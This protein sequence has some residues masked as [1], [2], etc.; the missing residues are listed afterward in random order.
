MRLDN[1]L[2]ENDY[3][4]TR[5]KA[6]IAIKNNN[7]LVNN[8]CINKNSYI[9]NS[10][11]EVKIVGEVLKYVSKGGLKLEKAINEFNIDLS[12][13]IMCDIGSSTG[14]FSD[15][16][17]QNNI[18]KIYAIDVGSN[19]MDNKIRNNKKIVLYEN[20]DF[21]K[22]DSNIL[23]DVDII[24]IDVS[25]ISVTKLLPYINKL[26]NVEEIVCLIKPQF[27]CGMEIASKYKGIIL[28]KDIHKNIIERVI[29]EF[30]NINYY[31]NGLTYS[32]IRGG[33]GN[34]EYLLYLT[35]ID[36]NY[37]YDI[38]NIIRDGFKNKKEI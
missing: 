2:V 38:D 5:N 6:Q 16:A 25:F 4:D 27:E 26:G 36:N 21:R 3:F 15:V 23:L 31:V 17:L 34:I 37:K 24:T 35:K 30:N 19:Q 1:Y 13:K 14:G 28:N 7:V 9:V 32:P 10:N 33:S 29:K 18:K 8:K 22:I 12:N 20:T 11:D